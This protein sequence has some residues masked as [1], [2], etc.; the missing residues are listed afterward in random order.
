[1]T[2]RAE[3]LPS[4]IPLPLPKKLVV[5]D[6]GALVAFA[7]PKCGLLFILSKTET[8]EGKEEKA[9]EASAHCV[10]QCHCGK[11]LESHYR[12]HCADCRD[13]LEAARERA[14]FMAATKL[15]IEEYPDHPVFWA[16]H[17]GD[18]NGDGY[19]SS[20]DLLLDHCEDQAVDVP[21]YVWACTRH[22]LKL[23]VGSILQDALEQ[24]DMDPDSANIPTPAGERLQAFIDVWLKELGVHSWFEDRS[25]AVVLREDFPLSPP[26]AA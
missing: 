2:Q 26:T 1:M 17:S 16:G 15:T 18:M 4:P 20:V 25:R 11:P 7:C 14:R 10:K 22:D 5:E 8:E 3:V 13:S 21:E 23:D 9:R 12:L 24:Q 6:T 19:F